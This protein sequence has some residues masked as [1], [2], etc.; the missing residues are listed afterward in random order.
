M[1][2]P[3]PLLALARIIIDDLHFSDGSMRLATPGGAGLHAAMGAALWWPKIA[4]VAGIGRDIH[5]VT[6]GILLDERFVTDGLLIRDPCCVRSKLVYRL[7]GERTE[8]SLLG[9]DHFVRLETA[10]GDIPPCL[11][12]A[13]GT[14][15]FRDTDATFWQG[16]ATM[17]PSLGT[18]LWELHA[19]AATPHHVPALRAFLPMADVFS[20]NLS[21][22]RGLFGDVPADTIPDR[23]LEAGAR[24]VLLRMGARGA[25]AATPSQRL[26]AIPPPCDVVDE[27]GGGNSFC[28]GFLAALCAAPGDIASA[29][30]HASASA[31]RTISQFGP[32][33]GDMQRARALADATVVAPVPQAAMA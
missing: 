12:P 32:A 3:R 15:I 25:I 27:T 22:A 13:A 1:S 20:L 5:D 16:V 11:L 26:H 9:P 2:D 29:L 14:Y 19:D 30:R 21:E 28:G 24:L 10:V 17:R 18:M 8:A 33:T 4:P 6:H 23:L 7:N 31:A